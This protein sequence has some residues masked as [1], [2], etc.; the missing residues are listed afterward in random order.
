MYLSLYNLRV[1]D[2]IVKPQLAYVSTGM[3][4]QKSYICMHINNQVNDNMTDAKLNQTP[5]IADKYDDL[6]KLRMAMPMRQFY[7]HFLT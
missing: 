2:I 1:S 5:I 7:C 6:G 4:S 3:E